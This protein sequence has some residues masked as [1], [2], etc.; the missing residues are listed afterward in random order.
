MTT[1]RRVLTAVATALLLSGCA[2]RRLV[3]APPSSPST[4]TWTIV[5]AAGIAA[6]VVLGVLLTLP[7]W[8]A[9]GGARLAVIVLTVQ[10]GAVAVAGTVVGAAAIRTWQLIERPVDAPPAHALLRLSR[11]DGDTALF[12]L[13][14]LLVAVSM[15]LVGTITA[16][17]ARFAAGADPLERSL[18]CGVLAVELGGAGYGVVRLV[19]G[20]HSWPYLAG[21]LAFV[22]IAVAF[23]TCWPTAHPPD[24][25]RQ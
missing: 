24:P 3:A 25:A 9:P 19:L 18:A 23:A 22:P 2:E 17:A 5:W 6:T 8:K 20:E 14:I 13:I 15:G 10:T 4:T 21:T 11:I 7:A 1:P 12:A 16:T